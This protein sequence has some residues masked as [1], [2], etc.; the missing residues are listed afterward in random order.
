MRTSLAHELGHAIM[1]RV[2]TDSMEDEAYAFAGELLVPEKEFRRSC[3]GNRITLQWLAHQKRFWQRSIAFLLFRVGFLDIRN[4]YQ[5]QYLW[6]QIS[7][8][9]WRTREPR[10][11]DFPH[12]Q[13]SIFPELLRFYTDDLGY[14]ASMLSKLLCISI[15]DLRDL[16]GIESTP[17]LYV[18]N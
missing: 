9:G 7:A 11:T 2:P 14:N 4:R 8:R 17:K 5:T 1:N 6:K 13:P 10:E 12:E 3:I 18:V 16:Y 15:D